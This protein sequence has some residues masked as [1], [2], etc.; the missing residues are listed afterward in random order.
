MIQTS[1]LRLRQVLT[2][3]LAISGGSVLDA[4]EPSAKPNILFIFSDDHAWQAIGAYESR[5][6]DIANTP[7]IDRLAK[8][9]MLF[10]KC[11]VTNALCGPSRA[12]V[13]TG[14]YGHLN[15]VTWNK[16]ARFDGSQETFPKLMRGHGYET[17]VIGKWHLGTTP[18]GF[19]YFDVM[20]GQGK[21]YNPLLSKG[22]AEGVQE[23]RIVEG[24]NS[25]VVAD[26]SIEWLRNGR[27][28]EKPFLL[29]AQFK[30]THHGWAPAPEEYDLYDDVEIPEPE[31]LFDDFSYRGTAIR[32]QTLTLYEDL[33]EGLLLGDPGELGKLDPEQRKAWNSYRAKD[34]KP[35]EAMGLGWNNNNK[36]LSR[37]K[38]QVFMKNFLAT[39]AGIDRN[40]GRIRDFLEEN[41]LAENTIVIYMADHGFFLGEHGFFDKRFMY[42][43]S[44]RTAFIVHWPGVVEHGV[45]NDEDIVSNLDIAS[46]FLDIAGIEI[47]EEIQGESLVPV[48]KGRTPEGWRK[49]FLY[50]YF[51]MANHNVPPNCGVTDGRYKLIYYSKAHEWEF[52]DLKTDPDEMV[53][54]YYV[55]E[56]QETIED[57]KEE[58][59]RL[60]TKYKCTSTI[61]FNREV[62]WPYEKRTTPVK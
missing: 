19:D 48:L 30:A 51:E 43:E 22:N 11:Y 41:D 50:E 27:D 61:D 29:M 13:L 52:F 18:T 20:S 44:L 56:Y 15:G 40:V 55:P 34:R 23:K 14:K 24:H 37:F 12:T 57:L 59:K 28:K 58:L 35:F 62:K 38:Y 46:T 45:V 9:G 6:K 2:L 17:A 3:F 47:P 21:Y 26:L 10:R 4:E 60:R 1:K 53:S 49:S 16:K 33:R 39:G 31:N 7:H 8:E 36:E 5:L 54:Q 42:E 32:N 25:N